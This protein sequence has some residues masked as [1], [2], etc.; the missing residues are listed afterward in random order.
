MYGQLTVSILY[1]LNPPVAIQEAALLHYLVH[2]GKQLLIDIR[3]FSTY[4]NVFRVH[5]GN[6]NRNQSAQISGGLV[7]QM[8]GFFILFLCV[9]NQLIPGPQDILL[10]LSPIFCHD[11]RNVKF[12]LNT[13]IRPAFRTVFTGISQRRMGHLTAIPVMPP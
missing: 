6:Q 11:I 4:V 8:N 5:H 9:C 12:I 2:I 3:N 1:Q 13:S 10:F 7:N